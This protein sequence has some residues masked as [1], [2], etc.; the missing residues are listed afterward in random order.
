LA[1]A[2]QATAAIEYAIQDLLAIAEGRD[3][4]LIQNLEEDEEDDDEVTPEQ[5]AFGGWLEKLFYQNRLQSQ[6]KTS[7]TKPTSPKILDVK[8]VNKTK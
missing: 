1:L 4:D 8:E 7:T 6:T 2:D 5:V 3:P